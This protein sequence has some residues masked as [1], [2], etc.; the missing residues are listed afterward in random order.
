LN[1]GVWRNYTPNLRRNDAIE[2][3]VLTRSPKP[4]H[5][6]HHDQLEIFLNET[7]KFLAG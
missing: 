1:Q 7:T 5:W 2:I 4:G 6:V 3:P